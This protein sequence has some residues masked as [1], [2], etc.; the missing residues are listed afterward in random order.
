MAKYYLRTGILPYENVT[1]KD[2]L[3]NNIFGGNSGNLLYQYS[4][5][6]HLS[7][8]DSEFLP[9][10]YALEVEDIDYINQTCDAFII[11]LSASF[12]DN[13]V[14]K[15]AKIT[16]IIKQLKI[17]TVIAGVGICDAFEPR[18]SMG[19]RNDQIVKEFVN[20]VLE[21][22]T[23]L[24]LR[25]ELTGE[26]LR[27]LGYQEDKH[28]MVIGCPSLYMNGRDSFKEMKTPILKKESVVSL[29]S[30]LA[31]SI[32][33][34]ELLQNVHDTYENHYFI[35]QDR[36]D[37]RFLYTGCSFSAYDGYF[38]NNSLSTDYEMD[39]ARFFINV[40]SWIDFLKKVDVSFGTRFHGTV[41]GLLAGTPSIVVNDDARKR[42][43]VAYHKI[44]HITIEQV[45]KMSS[46]EEVVNSVDFSQL[47]KYHNQN[48]DRYLSFL[49]RNNLPTIYENF[50]DKSI[51]ED[52]MKEVSKKGGEIKPWH[53]NVED[54]SNEQII[55]KYEEIRQKHDK[56]TIRL[57]QIKSDCSMLL[58]WMSIKNKGKR[59]IDYI[60]YKEYTDFC[61]YGDEK[62]A[63]KIIEELKSTDSVHYIGYFNKNQQ[64]NLN[65]LLLNSTLKTLVITTEKI[66]WKD[67]SFREPRNVT[68]LNIKDILEELK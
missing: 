5:I 67:N 17:P 56:A 6:K 59:V 24:G 36:H 51:F 19:E 3:V 16:K 25:G 15:L 11:P 10:R 27:R 43:L 52:K 21:S 9:N 32:D 1:P 62:I 33:T 66:R 42:E 12:R 39:K 53:P 44:P 65:E 18:F 38:C 23:V 55:F 46:L 40:P 64:S 49:K 2:C 28:Y 20:A 45:R 48:F 22:G 37:L 26:Y 31:E 14:S 68:I 13:Y 41:A 60:I 61:V 47:G 35:G 63:E 58:D 29:N 34:A 57:F 54:N 7:V 50:G 8:S 30:R 4:L